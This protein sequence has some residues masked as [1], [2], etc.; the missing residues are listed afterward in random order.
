MTKKKPEVPTSGKVKRSTVYGNPRSR[1]TACK[2][3]VE[4][5]TFHLC[6][7]GRTRKVFINPAVDP[8]E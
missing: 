3:M 2:H 6:P 5:G 1:C 4:E 8:E 7:K